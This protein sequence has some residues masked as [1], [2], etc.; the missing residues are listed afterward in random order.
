MFPLS[1]NF[2]VTPR[3]LV[4]PNRAARLV[5]MIPLLAAIVGLASC[6]GLSPQNPN[7]LQT[8]VAAAAKSFF[9][10]EMGPRGQGNLQ[11]RLS[12]SADLPQG[13]VG[14]EYKGAISVTG[15]TQP[16]EFS[17]VK[18]TLPAGLSLDPSTGLISGAP[19]ESGTRQ[20]GI[21]VIDFNQ[22]AVGVE[23]LTIKVIPAAGSSVISVQISPASTTV[24]SRGSVQFSATVRGTSNTGTTW[25][26][27]AGTVSS[28]GLFEAPAITAASTATVIATSVADSSKQAAATVSISAPI[29]ASLPVIT[30]TALAAAVAGVPYS[31]MLT[32][33]FGK[34]PYVW[35][36][37]GTLPPGFRLDSASGTIDGTTNQSGT[38]SFM[39]KVTDAASLS[40]TKGFRLSVLSACGPP[41]YPCSGS[42]LTTYQLPNPMPDVGN[43][44]GMNTVITDLSIPGSANRIARMTD[45]NFAPAHVNFAFGTCTGGSSD[46]NQWNTDST[47]TLA[48]DTG[49]T[50]YP[51]IFDPVTMQTARMYVSSFPATGGLAL[52]DGGNWSFTNSQV[53]FMLTGAVLSKYDFTNRSTPPNPTMLFNYASTNC[54]G[55]G[56][57]VTHK[58]NGGHSKFPADRYFGG[59]FSNSG[60]QGTDTVIAVVDAVTGQCT[61]LNTSTGTA[62]TYGGTS[63]GTV[64]IPDRFT[65]HN[66]KIFL[67]GTWMVVVRTLSGCLTT[68][69][70]KVYF[71]Q[72]GTNNLV[73]CTSACG[74]HFTRGVTHLINGGNGAFGSRQSQPYTAFGTVTQLIPNIGIPSGYIPP[75]DSHAGYNN[76][77]AADTLPFFQIGQSTVYDG[78]NTLFPS[79]W[80]NEVQA[81]FVDGSGRVKRFAHTY[82]SGNSQVFDARNA[83]MSISQD[84]RFVLMTSDWMYTLGSTT[85]T[86]GCTGGTDCRSDVFA[87]ELK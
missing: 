64:A 30:S 31:A 68:C 25:S 10:Y 55:P 85:G 11:R 42:S 7:V 26:A 45:A 46:Q 36:V 9:R 78:L 47:L 38:F 51:V 82:A 73:A 44:T 5:A 76:V 61:T 21:R 70:S 4:G 34:Q 28:T 41:T 56:Y 57:L 83:I 43:L 8:R 86:S 20:S 18:G 24:A 19:L 49:G 81:V 77:D 12:I 59:N 39:V 79:A 37:S 1:A 22:T 54:L 62:T 27:T 6:S 58:S 84:G 66:T 15:G 13:T 53:F 71:W 65:I 69:S 87:V 2:F 80:Y 63:A 50:C 29:Q 72:P 14:Q 60:G 74:G 3:S 23:M 16:Y 48:G 75:N 33:S 32:A 67:D 35:G 17:I 40:D 52:V